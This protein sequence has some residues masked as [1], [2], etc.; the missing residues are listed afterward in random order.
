MKQMKLVSI[1]TLVGLLVLFVVQNAE[2]LNVVFLVWSF[3]IRRALLIF[4][5]LAIGIL[6]GWLL[7]LEQTRRR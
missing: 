4:V 3:E 5:V 6:I 2:V 7:R 1:L